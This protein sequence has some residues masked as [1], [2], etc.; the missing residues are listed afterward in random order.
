MAVHDDV[1]PPPQPNLRRSSRQFRPLKHWDQWW[2]LDESKANLVS[3]MIDEPSNVQEDL[4]GMDK[5]N[6]MAAIQKDM[7]TMHKNKI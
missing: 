1:M 5:D 4:K 7:D 6:W 3:S 2:I